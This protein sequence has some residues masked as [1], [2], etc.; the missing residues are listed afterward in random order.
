VSVSWFIV[1]EEEEEVVVVVVEVEAMEVVAMRYEWTPGTSLDNR[2]PEVQR[3]GP[4]AKPNAEG[5]CGLTITYSRTTPL[6]IHLQY[7]SSG[8]VRARMQGG[9][10]GHVGFSRR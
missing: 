8:Q 1:E 3:T 7:A 2:W 6:T 5:P 10:L 4:S 9:P